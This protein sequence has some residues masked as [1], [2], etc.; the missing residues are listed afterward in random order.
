MERRT[1][2]IKNK[3]IELKMKDKIL[4]RIEI[5]NNKVKGGLDLEEASFGSICMAI[6]TLEEM[7]Q[8][9]LEQYQRVSLILNAQGETK[10]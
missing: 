9:L 6:A 3:P 8:R 10:N 1:R 4:L 7:K 2:N 5:Q